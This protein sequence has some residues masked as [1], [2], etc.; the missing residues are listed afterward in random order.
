MDRLIVEFAKALAASAI[1]T[2][3]SRFPSQ[4]GID[5]RA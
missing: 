3:S 2:E 1:S 5:R 4:D